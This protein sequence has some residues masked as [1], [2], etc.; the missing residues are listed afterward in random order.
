MGAIEDNWLAVN[1]FHCN[2][3]AVRMRPKQCEI[4]KRDEHPS[5]IKCSQK[6]NLEVGLLTPAK[7]ECNKPT[8]R[9]MPGITP[10]MSHIVSGD[11]EMRNKCMVEGCDKLRQHNKDGMC[12]R[13]WREKTGTPPKAWG[14]NKKAV[15][16]PSP[17]PLIV[18]QP[19]GNDPVLHALLSCTPSQDGLFIP[20]DKDLHQK[21]LSHGIKP[22]N[23]SIL[24]RYLV[25]GDLR[26]RNAS[27]PLSDCA[28]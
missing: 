14:H 20:M 6:P 15:A 19:K 9:N 17:P 11:I 21:V 13:H 16:S 2:R 7:R 27:H 22:E 25:D 28:D 1:T 4:N 8:K 23:I 18:T 24:L 26:W 5:C 3:L 12:D 10:L